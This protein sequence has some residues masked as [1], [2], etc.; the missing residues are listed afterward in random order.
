MKKVLT[1]KTEVKNLRSTYED[2]YYEYDNEYEDEYDDTYDTHNVGAQDNDNEDELDELIKVRYVSEYLGFFDITQWFTKMTELFHLCM[3]FE[4]H[5]RCK[6]LIW[7]YHF[8]LS[9]VWPSMPSSL[10]SS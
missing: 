9:P 6:M 8:S 4:F 5:S 10:L 7:E 3:G 2:Y 1:D